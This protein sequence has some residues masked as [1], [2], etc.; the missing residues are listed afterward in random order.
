MRQ[1]KSLLRRMK[2]GKLPA[3]RADPESIF[4]AERTEVRISLACFELLEVPAVDPAEGFAE[5]DGAFHEIKGPIVDALDKAVSEGVDDAYQLQQTIR[6]V[7]GRWVSGRLR[8][9]PMIIPI[10]LEA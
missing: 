4:S 7:V 6:R 9:R 5:Q 8:R 10:V 3:L 2:H 1:V